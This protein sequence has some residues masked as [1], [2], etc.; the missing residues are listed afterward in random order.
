MI[1]HLREGIS[2]EQADKFAKELKAIKID[3]KGKTILVTSTENG[4]LNGVGRDLVEKVYEFDTD[5]QLANADY[6]I[7]KRKI[8]IGPLKFGGNLNNTLVI[9][10][11]CAIE[12]KE[13]VEKSASFLKNLGVQMMRAGSYKPRTSPYS[14]QGL[15][16]KGL[17]ILDEI[18]NRFGLKIVTEVKDSTHVQEVIE[19]A[20]LVQIGAKAMFDYAI[21]EACGKS[22]KPVMIKRGFGATA[23]ELVQAAEFVLALGNENVIVCERGIRTFENKTRFTLDLSGAIYIKHQTNLP[24]FLDPSHGI[25]HAYGVPDLARACMAAGVEGLLIET[26]PDPSNAL[27]DSSQQLHHEDF[28]ALYSSLKKVGSAIGYSVI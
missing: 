7:S 22:N 18:R 3:Q 28:K 20:D 11:P 15:G 5:V 13:Q 26:H 24:L 25:G 27:S 1:I 4:G 2:A 16:S 23:Q 21:L 19:F 9:A 8:E 14:F 6:V 17:Q 12:S 10:G